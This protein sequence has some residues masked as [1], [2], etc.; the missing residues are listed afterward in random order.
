MMSDPLVYNEINLNRG[1]LHEQIADQIQNMIAAQRLRPGDKLPNER[2]LAKTLGVSRPTIREAMR[3]MQHRGLI[4]RKPGGGTYLI[5]MGTAALSE[6][7]DRYF[8]IKDCSHDDLFQVRQGLEPVA[9][10]LAAQHATPE[11]I[12]HLEDRLAKLNEAFLS[13]DPRMLASTDSEFHI[14]IAQA[15]LNPL[16]AAICAGIDDLVRKWN[17]R[18]STEIFDEPATQ[19]HLAILLAIKDRDPQRAREA[20]L[21]HIHLSRQVFE[22]TSLRGNGDARSG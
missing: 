12:R 3:L 5:Q 18:S 22:R 19:S 14:A 11:V 15:S 2:D 8:W 1:P 9:A 6:S 10:A 4:D 13:G 20:A 16:L 17:E 7:L 21:A